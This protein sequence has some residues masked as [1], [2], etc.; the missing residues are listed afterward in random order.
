MTTT[1]PRRW[2]YLTFDEQQRIR[3][4][5]PLFKVKSIKPI[6]KKKKPTKKKKVLKEK[7]FNAE[8]WMKCLENL[9]TK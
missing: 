9:K 5:L 4:G 8:E 3:K 1:K 6:L 2:Q 7:L